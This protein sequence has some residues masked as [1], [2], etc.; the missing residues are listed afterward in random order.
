MVYFKENPFA[1]LKINESKIKLGATQMCLDNIFIMRDGFLNTPADAQ[2][3]LAFYGS[4]AAIGCAQALLVFI[5]EKNFNRYNVPED[6][7]RTLYQWKFNPHFDEEYDK[8]DEHDPNKVRYLV[9]I[10]ELKIVKKYSPI[11]DTSEK[12]I[13]KVNN[14]D[15][16]FNLPNPDT[17][18]PLNEITVRDLAAIMLN[19]PVSNK[20]WLNEIIKK[21]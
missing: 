12:E 7:E 18:P 20:E 1:K 5:G 8:V 15:F 10:D 6:P 11:G 4:E 9:P 21:K 3:E 13:K 19:K 14:N 16:D 2:D 17:D